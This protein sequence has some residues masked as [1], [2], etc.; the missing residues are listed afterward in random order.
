[1][2]KQ[3]KHREVN[4]PLAHLETGWSARCPPGI[5]AEAM[6]RATLLKPLSKHYCH[7]LANIQSM[8]CQLP[9]SSL[10]TFKH[11][12]SKWTTAPWT[13]S[14]NETTRQKSGRE[15]AVKVCLSATVVF[16][17]L[18]QQQTGYKLERQHMMLLRNTQVRKQCQFSDP[19]R[20]WV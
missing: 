8:G 17:S 11:M 14:Q 3:G 13:Y 6:C 16:S 1:M 19:R 20:G 12:D 9:L 10:K 15:S 2:E 5:P 18:R 4:V 7:S